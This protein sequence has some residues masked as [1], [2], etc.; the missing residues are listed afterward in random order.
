M[1]YNH[2]PHPLI[3]HTPEGV[4]ELQPEVDEDGKSL[5]PR[6]EH[7]VTE[8]NVP[9]HIRQ[10]GTGNWGFHNPDGPK[11][12][13]VPVVRKHRNPSVID[14]EAMLENMNDDD[15]VVVSSMVAEA[16]AHPQVWSPDEL[17]RDEKGRITGCAGL[18]CWADWE[19]EHKTLTEAQSKV[20][21]PMWPQSPMQPIPRTKL[22]PE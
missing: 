5:V 13:N 22:K 12:Y 19:Y 3:I 17:I 9:D 4:L 18:A 20:L 15:I 14:T 11:C 16:M 7:Q 21:H 1:I 10:V 6:V 2:T 8:H